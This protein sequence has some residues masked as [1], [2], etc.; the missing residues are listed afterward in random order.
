MMM[1]NN[2]N[3]NGDGNGN[4]Q[5]TVPPGFRFHPTD[6]ELLYYYLKKKVSYEPIDF[7]VIR[8]IDLNKLEPW[9]LRDKCGIGSGPQNEWYFFSHKDKKY[10]TGSRT[11]RATAAG[12]W[13]ATGR[14]KPIHHHHADKRIGMRKTLVFY[15][16]RAPHGHK[17][18]WIMHEY[19]L[20]HTTSTTTTNTH[21]LPEEG[22]VI[23]RVFKKKT[24]SNPS[25][26]FH[27]PYP[28]YPTP[29]TTTTTT[30]N[31]TVPTNLPNNFTMDHLNTASPMHLPQ[32]LC[33]DVLAA[34]G[35]NAPAPLLPDSALDIQTRQSNLS[36]D[37]TFL[38]KL[39]TTQPGMTAPLD[40]CLAPRFSL[41]P[42]NDCHSFDTD[43]SRF[44][45]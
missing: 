41:F 45:K 27:H 21:H 13:K 38:D 1:S 25:R 2:S 11:N 16:G 36:G 17:T 14:D 6:E 8:E 26:T 39:L 44:P 33:P 37:W 30:N 28:H 34:I 20:H 42:N 9:D 7:D 22:W 31:F 43:F 12:F 4:G 3:G 15:T 23:C 5:L 40:K 35:G 29:T 19:R 10:P 32:L 18:D 24:L